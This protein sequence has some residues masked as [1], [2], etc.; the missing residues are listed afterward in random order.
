MQMFKDEVS[1]CYATNIDEKAYKSAVKIIHTTVVE[2]TI[3]RY[4]NNRVLGRAPPPVNDK[5]ES[6][7]SRKV[8]ATLSQLRSGFCK[9][10]NDYNNRC[11]INIPNICPNCSQTPHNTA[12]LFNCPSKPS[13]LTM[14]SLW[15]NPKLAAEFLKLDQEQEPELTA[16]LKLQQQQLAQVLQG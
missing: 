2:Q 16:S 10:W 13:T 5:E 15:Y 11:N 14:E 4:P 6:D 12:H 1:P 9:L 8:R 3:S 7:L